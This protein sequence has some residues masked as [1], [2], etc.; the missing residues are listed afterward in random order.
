[1]PDGLKPL[2][3]LFV[4][5]IAVMAAIVVIKYAASYLPSNGIPGAAKGLINV[6]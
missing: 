3:E 1:M 5:T 4:T 6:V 2:V